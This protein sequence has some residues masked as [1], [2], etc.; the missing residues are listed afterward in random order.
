MIDRNINRKYFS[1][2]KLDDFFDLCFSVKDKL[3]LLN[4]PRFAQFVNDDIKFIM[5]SVRQVDHV[6]GFTKFLI[7][8]RIDHDPE[9][10]EILADQIKKNIANF[11]TD[12][13]L[14]A[15]VNF[16][17]SLNPETTSLF[18]LANDEF[19]YRLDSNFNAT[20]RDLY[21]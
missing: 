10:Y 19:I 18:E 16:S 11:N 7:Y 3:V 20:S 14:T 21:I 2:K 12:E 8:F 5:Q 9:L 1:D 13:L 17:H 4:E 6:V 15:L